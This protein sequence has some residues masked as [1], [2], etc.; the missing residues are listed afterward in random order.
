MEPD[1]R[2]R[3]L[4]PVPLATYVHLFNGVANTL[5]LVPRPLSGHEWEL[6]L[7]SLGQRVGVRTMSMVDPALPR[8]ASP[9]EAGAFIA[10]VMFRLWFGAPARDG[11]AQEGCYYINEDLPFLSQR[12]DPDPQKEDHEQLHLG[13]FVAGMIKGV[14]DSAGFLCDTSAMYR[15]PPMPGGASTQFAIHWAGSVMRR[16]AP[17]KKT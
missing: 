1:G 9:D 10:Q 13:A 4:A 5:R 16:T 17:A 8:L 2:V 3:P 14:L 7:H 11:F 6:R 15:A 12:P